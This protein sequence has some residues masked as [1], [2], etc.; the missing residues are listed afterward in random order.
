MTD[1]VDPAVHSV[2][3]LEVEPMVNRIFSQSHLNQLRARY[4]PV[5]LP[6]QRCDPGVN[7]TLG[8]ARPSQPVYFAG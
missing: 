4:H 1:R 2:Q 8:T 5:L 6:S 3:T 7:P